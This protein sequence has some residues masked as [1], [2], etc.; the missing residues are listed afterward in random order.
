MSSLCKA[1]AV[2]AAPVMVLFFC[3]CS[4]LRTH[5]V[6]AVSA[7]QSEVDRVTQALETL[8]AASFD[9]WK[10]SPALQSTAPDGGALPWLFTGDPTRPDFDDSR[11]KDVKLGEPIDL[12]SC[13]MRKAIVL[14][15]H[16]LGQPVSGSVKFRLSSAV[17]LELWVNGQSKGALGRNPELELT[18]DAKPGQRFVV[19]VR[20]TRVTSGSG[21]R[22]G[23]LRLSRAELS[24]QRAQAMRQQLEDLIL[25]LR[26]G[27]KLLSFDTYQTNARNK[28]DP[29]IDKSAI[30]KA[31]RTRLNK[32]LQAL[33]SQIDVAALTDGSPDKFNASVGALRAKLGPIREFAQQFTL[34]FDANAHIDA[35]WLW[36][37]KE[38][39]EV[40][41]NTFSSVLNMMNLRPD[42]T[43]TQSTAAYYDWMERLNPDLFK[44][45]QQRVKDGRWEVV[46]GMWVE[47]DCNLPSGESWARHLLYSKRY[48]QNKLG[49]DVKIGWNPDSFGYTWNIPMFYAN[50]GIDT[51]I[52]QKI[53]W[54]ETNVFPHRVF[55]WE[56]PDGSRVLTYFPFSYVNTID[57]PFRLVDWLRQFEANSG[58]R[59]L[60]ILFG[61]GDHGGG[62]SLQM[63]DRIEHLKTLD[64]F[65][66]IEYGTAGTYLDWLKQQN[67]SGIPKWEDE[68]YLE[69]HQG[70]YTTQA[71]MKEYNRTSEVLLTNAE[72]L[73]SLASLAGR[74]YNSANLE[75]AWWSVLFN[76]FHDILPGSG[77]H[78]NYIDATEKYRQAEELGQFE[79]N[80]SLKRIA[81]DANTSSIRSGTPIIVFNALSWTRTDLV[82]LPLSSGDGS[83]YAI[84]DQRGQEV[85]SQLEQRDKLDRS[86][87]FV[88]K[89]VPSVGYTVLEL[90]KQPARREGSGLRVS[91]SVNEN[92]PFRVTV[93]PDSGWV[94]SIVDKRVGREI[95]SG[96]GNELQLLED[97]PA[98]WDAWNIGLTGVKYPSKLRKIEVVERGPVRSTIR[99]TRDYLKP[100]VKKGFPTEDFPTSFFTQEISLYGGLDRIDFKTK[101]DW[102][103]EHTMLK[104]AFP[105]T[106]SDQKATY[107]IPFGTIRRSTLSGSSWE[108]A[109]VEVPAERWADL[110]QE[111]YG[112]SLLSKTK[113]GYDIKG[114]VIRL[115]LLRSPKWPDPLADRGEHL[116]EY[117]L[118]PHRARVE[119][120][121]TVQRGYQYNNPL[122]AI[123]TDSHKG[124]RPASYSFVQLAPAN[125]ILT[126][127]KK[128]EDGEAWIFQWY[129]AK[130]EDS[131]AKLTLP[132]A[133]TK[134]VKSSF[135]ETDGSAE[136]FKGTQVEVP[137]KKNATTTVKIYFRE[138]H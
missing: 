75:E 105:V 114:N 2:L 118:Y 61:V 3:G 85:P 22:P 31:E 95:L 29:G 123:V 45:I 19:V 35:A 120:A 57:N 52:T 110:S 10:V 82:T 100:G 11:W 89:D 124:R 106:V 83:D 41:K 14:P 104:V 46:G 16:L 65:P 56:S 13:W 117:A 40:V 132:R 66:R 39:V 12:E 109:K 86:I 80:Q 32:L 30:D 55:W 135:L 87:V 78:E 81:E 69:Y 63:I 54:N 15:E 49:L 94:K 7:A 8:S 1:E 121:N 119:E 103:E 102:W 137:T 43:Y 33:A 23:P 101:V 131:K 9:D 134:V 125:L 25:S 90:R 92:D 127:I 111:D 38:T 51:F 99:I 59:K 76:Q 130:G 107:E 93:D 79:L 58:F 71:K 116:I 20:A 126:T 67:L 91:S 128:A 133:P 138:P 84:F 37:D 74:K 98:Q 68:L 113:Y 53:S 17:A 64:L 88:A 5:P 4:G 122:I 48:F 60:M 26:V 96:L 108:K 44:G 21:G 73:S 50:A 34:Y 36:R 62:P 112:V 70:T 6:R 27:Q 47:P 129:D 115:S 77:I 97:T 18:N 28:V 42:F 72:K 24:L 136:V